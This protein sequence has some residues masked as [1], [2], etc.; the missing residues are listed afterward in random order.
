MNGYP[1][2]DAYSA[3][4]LTFFHFFSQFLPTTSSIIF[5]SLLLLFIG[6]T[7]GYAI[8]RSLSFDYR[9][10]IVA[11]LLSLTPAYVSLFESWNLALVAYGLLFLGLIRF[12]R[13]EERRL[14]VLFSFVGASLVILSSIYQFYMYAIITAAFLV[15]AYFTAETPKGK[16]KIFLIF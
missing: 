10:S 11:G 5:S 9:Y 7:L 15:L 8:A 3:N 2:R 16:K 12:Y 1:I 4:T 14:F 6:F 13:Y